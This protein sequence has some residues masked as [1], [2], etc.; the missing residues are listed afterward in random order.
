MKPTFLFALALSAQAAIVPYTVSIA[1]QG[2]NVQQP[3]TY[4]PG[5]GTCDTNNCIIGLFTFSIGA[6]QFDP[7]FPSTVSGN[8]TVGGNVVPFDVTV[9]LEQHDGLI[10]INPQFASA[11]VYRTAHSSLNNQDPAQPISYLVQ[12]QVAPEPGTWAM[13]AIGLLLIASL[14]RRRLRL[15]L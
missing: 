1:Q 10:D 4:A 9:F 15:L 6:I 7:I 12:A 13:G 8:V 2:G 3:V 14:R 5:S 11:R